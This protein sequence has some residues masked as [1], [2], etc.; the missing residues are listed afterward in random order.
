MYDNTSLLLRR[1]SILLEV[2]FVPKVLIKFVMLF[3]YLYVGI[4]YKILKKK[5]SF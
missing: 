3:I 2:L 4:F 1:F 5:A